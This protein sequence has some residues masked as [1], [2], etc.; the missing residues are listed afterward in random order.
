MDGFWSS[1]T[2]GS[3]GWAGQVRAG[4]RGRRSMSFMVELH[5]GAGGGQRPAPPDP[6]LG[7]VPKPELMP[8]RLARTVPALCQP[9]ACW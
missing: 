6:F 1:D 3:E 4:G 7:S 9:E 8:L 5:G 2:L